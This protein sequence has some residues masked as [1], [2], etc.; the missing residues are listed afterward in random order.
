MRYVATATTR[1]PDGRV[2]EAGEEYEYPQ[3]VGAMPETLRDITQQ[4]FERARAL[5]AHLR[6]E[7]E[8]VAPA[9]RP[10]GRPRK[11]RTVV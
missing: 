7:A 8:E 2:F 9:K 6:G 5:E 11:D 1:L 4:E 10:R 3:E